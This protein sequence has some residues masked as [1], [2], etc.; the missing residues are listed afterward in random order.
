MAGAPVSISTVFA[1]AALIVSP[2]GTAAAQNRAVLTGV[3]RAQSGTPLAGARVRFDTEP[4]AETNPA[5]RF[6]IEVPA[7]QPGTLE[8]AAVGFT[9]ERVLIP[10]LA[11]GQI[12]EVAA[13]LRALFLLDPLAIAASR[14]RPLLDTKDATTGGAVEAAEIA[15]LPTDARDPIALLFNVPGVAQATSYFGDAPTLSFNG[16]NSLYTQYTVD[17]LDANEG[18]LGGPRVELPLGAIRR[19][20]ARVNSYSTEFGRSAT[21]LVD[22][23][24]LGGGNRVRGDVFGYWR[25]GRPLDARN[26]TPFGGVPEAIARQQDGFQRV[27]LGG[28]VAGPLRRDRT[29]GA[30]AMEYTSE[31]ED[32]IGSTALAPFLGTEDRSKIKAFARLDHAWSDRQ[33]T[34]LRFALSSVRRAGRGSGVLTPEADITTRRVG[35]LIGVTHRTTLGGGRSSNSASVQVGTFRWFFPPTASDFSRPQ[36]TVVTPGQAVQAIV[37]SSNFVFDETETQLQLRDVFATTRGRH[38][39]QVGADLITGRFRL[40]AAGTNPNGSYRVI[41]DGNIAA[42]PGQPLSISDIPANVRVQEYVI[43]ASPQQ[44]DLTQTVV[45]AFLAD[46]WRVSPSFT[47]Q[48]G[49]RWDYDD[50][51]SRGRSTADLDNFQPRASFNWYRGGGSVMRGGL[52]LYTGKLPYAI[53]SDAI[54]LGPDGNAVVT[55]AGTDAPQYLKGPTPAQLQ[56]QR[57]QL[58]PR[59]VFETFAL[60]LKQPRSLQASLGWQRPLGDDWAIA[61]DAVW[62][63][64]RNLPRNLDLNP[65]PLRIGP[66][67]LTD[68]PCASAF[69]CPADQSRPDPPSAG[70]FRRRSTSE[71]G[72]RA[73]YLGLYTAVRRRVGRLTL[74][75]NWVWSRSKTDTEDIN[76]TAAEANCFSKDRVDAVTGAGCTSTEWAFA[77]NDRRHHV[78][79]RSVVRLSAATQ[80]SVIGDFQTGQPINR[81]AGSSSAAGNATFD[82]LGV[83]PVRG[84]AFLGNGPRFFGVPRNGERLPAY[85]DLRASLQYRMPGWRGMML[86]VDGFNLLDRTNWAGFPIGVGGAGSRIQYGRP[87][88]PIRLFSPGP[89]RQFQ[90][91]AQYQI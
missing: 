5:G 36:V 79:L 69:A 46:V 60:G 26:K 65:S 7:G 19:I 87:G 45:G 90:V 35:S 14:E 52:G 27:Q 29:F 73:N 54:Q 86:R 82:L 64:T 70:G 91:S 75:A 13:T 1:L 16:G 48:L 44:V 24:T 49:V 12:R 51:T 77:N 56:R 43:D 21:G 30:A 4:V 74:D 76:F 81:L 62:S 9:P 6:R 32:R 11:A 88:D 85:F 53:Y 67:D 84:N 25:P 18:F 22:L 42:R 61:I 80:V 20:D 33:A 8:L 37:G 89:P 3:V 83:G 47:V 39:L 2:L 50:L 38:T 63:E 59:E 40:A 58:P 78:T 68:R 41:N 28:S 15:A 66:D 23:Q 71:S 34:T 31:D 55:F 57:S 17:G 10:G 72:G